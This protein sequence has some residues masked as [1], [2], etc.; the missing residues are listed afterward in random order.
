MEI[1]ADRML[2]SDCQ[3][4]FRFL[5]DLRNHWQL[6]GRW[7]RVI[8]LTPSG[9]EPTGAWV[10]LRG[11]IGIRRSVR[12]QVVTDLEARQIHGTA[13]LAPAT[14]AH[15][16]WSLAPRPDGGTAVRL[17]AT[18]SSCGP[19]EWLVL[20]LG[21]RHWLRRRF[22]ATLAQLELALAAE[23]GRERTN[24]EKQLVR[25]RVIEDPSAL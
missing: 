15:V 25:A 22:H 9:R 10:Q 20:R 14:K 19:L 7:V 5:S 13:E 8:D 16:S 23:D 1:T 4:V 6:T 12:T 21:G 18:V 3:E 2:P 24:L 17:N 11:P